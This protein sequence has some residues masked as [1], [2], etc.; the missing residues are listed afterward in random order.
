MKKLILSVAALVVTLASSYGQGQLFFSNRIL[1]SIDARVSST[2]ANQLGG[3]A[4]GPAQAQ[5]FI[6]NA[7]GDAVTPIASSLTA[8][9]TGSAAAAGYISG[10]G[11][12]VPGVDAGT[13]IKVIMVG[14]EGSDFASA[15]AKGKSAPIDVTLGGG[16]IPVPNLTGLQGFAIVPEPSTIVLGVLGAA[17]LLFR[18]RK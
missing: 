18:R 17:A 8:F 14:F 4:V 3:F 13:T 11:V 2:G 1:P 5:L 16:T 7:A 6:S 10:F 15:G 9:R 12:T